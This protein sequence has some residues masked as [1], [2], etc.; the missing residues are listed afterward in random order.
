MKKIFY[1]ILIL[2][3]GLFYIPYYSQD[4]GIPKLFISSVFVCFFLIHYALSY[5]KREN[6]KINKF[7]ILI[8][9]LSIYLII[10]SVSQ[11]F[12]FKE[13]YFK[14]LSFSLVIFLFLIFSIIISNQKK[15]VN[16]YILQTFILLGLIIS[17]DCLL[18]FYFGKGISS[19]FT[20]NTFNLYSRSNLKSFIG[21]TNFTTSFIGMLIPISIFFSIT[22]EKIW[23]SDRFRKPFYLVSSFIFFSIILIGQTRGVILSLL[24]SLSILLIGI[25]I[26]IFKNKKIKIKDYIKLSNLFLLTI[27]FMLLIFVFSTDNIFTGNG[28]ININTRIT[29]EVENTIPFD[30]RFQM[31]EASIEIF[32]T[33]PLFGTGFNTYKYHSTEALANI[34][35]NSPERYLYTTFGLSNRAH[36]EYFQI[37]SET[38]LIGFILVILSILYLIFY[39]VKTILYVKNTYNILLFLFIT[40]SFIIIL[41]HS[42][43]SFPSHLMPNSLFAFVILGICFSS[44]F[45]HS[46]MKNYSLNSKIILPI[47]LT[48]VSILNFF[49][50]TKIFLSEYYYSSS[51]LNN[52]KSNYISGL[53]PE[54]KANLTLYKTNIESLNDFSGKFSYLE[55]ETYYENS[56]DTLKTKYPDTTESFINFII[57]Q[58]RMEEINSLSNDFNTNFENYYDILNLQTTDEYIYY[59]KGLLDLESSLDND[60]YFENTFYMSNYINSNHYEKDLMKIVYSNNVENSLSQLKKIFNEENK[61]FKY[62]NIFSNPKEIIKPYVEKCGNLIFMNLAEIIYENYKK[63]NYEIK[64]TDY[65]KQIDIGSF[66]KI[67]DYYD[68]IM[69]LIE[70]QQFIPDGNIFRNIGLI[71]FKIFNLSDQILQNDTIANTENLSEVKSLLL[72]LKNSYKNLFEYSYDTAIYLMPT[73][74]FYYK[75]YANQLALTYGLDSIDK[76]FE[77]GDKEL[78]AWYYIKDHRLWIPDN[79]FNILCVLYLDIPENEKQIYIVKLLDMYEDAYNWAKE[80]INQYE[81]DEV[82]LDDEDFNRLNDMIKRYEEL[83]SL[84]KGGTD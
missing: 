31:W 69:F 13:V 36:N 12:Y 6:L 44:E 11:F 29:S 62:I 33:S 48:I 21:N 45:Y 55:K 37:L 22:K 81:S 52:N 28:K 82:S 1:F 18:L 40:A 42:F 59:L 56:I 73:H 43:V 25:L 60:K 2:C 16:L 74:E 65:L 83:K 47:F 79:A 41:S 7:F 19:I 70:S 39:W 78:Y 24:L 84:E 32:K 76:L 49:L 8:F 72:G 5:K 67:Q 34:S 75:D 27:I 50:I 63:E 64:W 80:K 46:K 26:Y 38:G 51:Y 30:Q 17:V 77:I 23:K 20:N 15:G 10:S 57:E 3:S 54:T 68:S 58:N 71:Y 61:F 66:I 9:I 4:L 53:I 14:S 35:H